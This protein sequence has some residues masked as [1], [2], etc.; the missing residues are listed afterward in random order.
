MIS[1]IEGFITKYVSFSDSYQ[2]PLA[3]WALC[4]F[5]Y[6]TFD[7]FP[8]ISITAMTKR[9]GKSRLGCDILSFICSNAR[10]FGSMSAAMFYRLIDAEHPTVIFDEA[11]NLSNESANDM[12][13]VLNAG[14]RRGGTVGRTVGGQPH[15]F[16]CYSPKVF[17]LIGDVYDTLRDRSIIVRMQRADAPARF[18]YEIAKEEGKTIREEASAM[19]NDLLPE[20]GQAY[21]DF[22]GLP[23]LTD[24]DEE[25]WTPLFVMAQV[26]CPERIP[27][28]SRMA[29]DMAMEKTVEKVRYVDTAKMEKE[30]EE[31]EYSVRLLND[32]EQVMNG[33]NI[34]SADAVVRL[35]ELPTGPW[36]KFRGEGV[37][38][39]NI[40]DMLA[41]FPGVRPVPIRSTGG[42]K[43]SKVFKGYRIDAVRA[44]IKALTV[45]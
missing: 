32:L 23:F 19:V 6:Q 7:A 44:A 24:R 18:L 38:M 9:S 40:A 33:K 1:K 20:I 10:Q 41:R 45:K 42:R 26:F 11:E 35:R 21:L 17:I 25:I 16:D 36:R 13:K 39:N 8:Y 22:K 5:V 12:R 30:A 34:S 14:Y 29:V 4:T 27:E 2:L 31:K 3:L 15:D 37:S 28:L 43:D